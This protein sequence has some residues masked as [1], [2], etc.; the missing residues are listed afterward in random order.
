MSES[1]LF[2]V[3]FNGPIYSIEV[4]GKTYRFEMHSY[5]GPLAVNKNDSIKKA[6]WPSAVWK[7]I[8]LWIDL[9][10]KVDAESRCLLDRDSQ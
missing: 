7:A 8:Q 2:N 9:G 4:D 3:T 6:P 1:L 5:F 10:E